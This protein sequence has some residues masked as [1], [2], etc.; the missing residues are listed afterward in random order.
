MAYG[1]GAEWVKF[2]GGLAGLVT[3]AFT[4]WDRAF[5]SHPWIE[6]HV[7][8]TADF[9]SA[10]FGGIPDDVTA[11]LRIFNPGPRTIGIGQ[12][13]FY[14]RT[15]DPLIALV[16]EVGRDGH[17]KRLLPLQAEE[18]ELFDLIWRDLLPG[19]DPERTIW[20]IVPWR[21]LAGILPRLPLVLRTSI[22]ALRRLQ[23]AKIQA[24]RAKAGIADH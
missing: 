17:P 8:M 18:A 24:A 23:D 6:P 3:F 5:R 20:V 4:V 14:P 12:V 7:F 9:R 1:P 13:R 19:E 22:A 16:D 2:W 10:M 21:P 15:P 11:S